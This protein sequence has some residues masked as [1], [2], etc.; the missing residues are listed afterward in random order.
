MAAGAVR[1]ILFAVTVATAPDL[2]D[3]PEVPEVPE[4]PDRAADVMVSAFPRL[5]VTFSRWC[6]STARRRLVSC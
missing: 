5:I 2:P 3:L 4:V 6:A 1:D